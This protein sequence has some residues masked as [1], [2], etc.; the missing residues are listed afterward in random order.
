MSEALRV[1]VKKKDRGRAKQD[2]IEAVVT[3]YGLLH[4]PTNWKKGFLYNSL[5]FGMF[6]VIFTFPHW[7]KFTSWREKRL[8]NIQLA[9]LSLLCFFRMTTTK[10]RETTCP[11]RDLVQGCLILTFIG[12]LYQQSRVFLNC[13]EFIL[14]DSGLRPL[15]W[16]R[17]KR[18]IT[19]PDCTIWEQDLT[20]RFCKTNLFLHY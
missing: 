6:T 10:P 16:L 3:Y 7:S 20:L 5:P 11:L 19:L 8:A 17:K 4:N 1:S 9:T 2:G 15:S 12:T 13:T 14:Y 18:A